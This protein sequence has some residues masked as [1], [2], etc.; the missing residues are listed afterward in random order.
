MIV[1]GNNSIL[2]CM[3]L[4]LCMLLLF[5]ICTIIFVFILY[6]YDMDFG[7]CLRSRSTC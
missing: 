6:A 5:I 4:V 3:F 2:C 7:G 1:I